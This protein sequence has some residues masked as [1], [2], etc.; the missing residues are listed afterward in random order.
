[1]AQ[2]SCFPQAENGPVFPRPSTWP[3]LCLMLWPLADEGDWDDKRDLCSRGFYFVF[4]LFNGSGDQV[5]GASADALGPP[6]R[7]GGLD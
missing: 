5:C 7:G 1:M 6:G 2:H 3:A 4:K